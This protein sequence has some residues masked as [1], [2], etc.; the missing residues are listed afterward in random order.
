MKL[1][2]MQLERL[3]ALLGQILPA[4]EFYARKLGDKAGPFSSL[5]E[6][7][8]AVPFTTKDELAVDHERHPPYGTTLT[9]PLETYTRFHQTSGTRGTPMA[10]LDDSEGWAWVLKSWQWVW[11]NAGAR[12]GDSAFFP[13][14]FGP[15]A[16]A[17]P[18]FI[19]P[20]SRL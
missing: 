10:W 2:D 7:A 18:L 9:F 13:F 8:A 14:S 1:G 4:N 6:F 12:S 3:N 19:L 20:T 16:C 15:S 11:A 5:E 17:G